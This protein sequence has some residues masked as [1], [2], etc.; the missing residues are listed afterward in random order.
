MSLNKTVILLFMMVQMISFQQLIY[1]QT[2]T[3]TQLLSEKEMQWLKEH[4]DITIAYDGFFPPYSYYS[5]NG[6]MIGLAVDIVNLL[7]KK[8]DIKFTVYSKGEWDILYDAAKKH[9]VDVIATLVNRPDRNEWFNFTKNYISMSTVLFVRDDNSSINI[10]S[11][12]TGKKVALVTGYASSDE[13][14]KKFP[15]IEPVFVESVLDGLISVS[16]A[17]ADVTLAT[18]GEASFY[19][20]KQGITNL[21]AAAVYSYSAS[22]QA[23]GIR[24]DWP[25]LAS[26]LEKGLSLITLSEMDSITHKWISF[27]QSYLELQKKKQIEDGKSIKID[28]YRVS[29]YFIL[30]M[31]AILAVLAGFIIWTRTLKR[32]VIERT[33]ELSASQKIIDEFFEHSPIHV[34]FKDKNLRSLKL[35]RNFEQMIGR[36]LD[37]LLY[38]TMD[39]LFPSELAKKMIE[40]D[41]QILKEGKPFIFEEELNG[42]NYLTYKFP[43]F[44]KGNPEYLAGY[45]I[46]VTE[47]I[48]AVKKLKVSEEKFKAVVNHLDMG[49]AVHEMIFDNEEKPVDY[50]FTE[51]NPGFEKMTGLKRENVIGK[52]C[53]EVLP[54]TEKSWIENYGKIVKTGQSVSFEDYSSEL[55]KWYKVFAYKTRENEFAVVFEDISERKRAEDLLKETAEELRQMNSFM[56]DREIRMVELKNEINEL[57]KKCGSEPKY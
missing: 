3:P 31:T 1:S 2:D 46:D 53:L 36:P 22:N 25:E 21:K 6:E 55:K 27:D 57:L 17:K 19:T 4:P 38:K 23:F 9:E 51:V 56:V 7:G 44:I 16:L 28:Y 10:P 26:I 15:G 18:I 37:E 30:F 14:S 42:K 49:M 50:R 29:K 47:R 48:E 11:D 20:S 40:D 8:L 35:S 41:K 52:T 43:I 45:T 39:E 24:K 33:K 32:K 13:L 5:D 54:G 12:L 34:Y